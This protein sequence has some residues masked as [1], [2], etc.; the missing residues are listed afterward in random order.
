MATY[1]FLNVHAS[2]A[3]PGGTIALGSGSGSAEEGI[4]ITPKEPLND[5]KVGAD[6]T[7]MNSLRAT[8]A[9]TVSISLLKTSP[10][11]NLLMALL[12]FQR[13]SAALH[14]QNVLVITDV[15]RGDVAACRSVAFQKVPDIAYAKDGN[16]IEWLFDA[17][18]IDETLGAGT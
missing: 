3:G 12:N 1:S 7:P 18:I 2:L 10:T 9:G 16:M 8:K 13:T 14:G 15:A 17:G 5:L 6:G 11:N 4:K